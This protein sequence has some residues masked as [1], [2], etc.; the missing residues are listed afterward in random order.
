MAMWTTCSETGLGLTQMIQF[1]VIYGHFYNFIQIMNS[2]KM[3]M[4]DFRTSILSLVHPKIHCYIT[5]KQD[6]QVGIKCLLTHGAGWVLQT[7]KWSSQGHWGHTMCSA[8]GTMVDL[9]SHGHCISK[10]SLCIV[11]FIYY[12]ITMILLYMFVCMYIFI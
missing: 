3:Q 9:D 8:T 1:L 10:G 12:I 4:V 6:L 5:K 7:L 11:Y 2:D